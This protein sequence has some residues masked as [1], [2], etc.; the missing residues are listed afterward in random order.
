[1]PRKVIIN[2]EQ[3]VKDYISHIMSTKDLCKSYKCSETYLYRILS[4]YNIKRNN[5]RKNN[6][7]WK[8]YEEIS[9]IYWNR[10]IVSAKKRNLAFDINIKEMW[11]LFLKQERKCSISG[12]EIGFAKTWATQIETTASIDR[13]NSQI[14]YI[15]TN[16]QWVHK[17]VNM[18]KQNMNE[19]E[20]IDWCNK[21]L[22]NQNKKLEQ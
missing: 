13:I 3:I 14:G 20:F 10:I 4:K 16:V 21:I 17:R 2:E 8:G 18:M 22:I 9:G 5:I 19:K 6:S 11:N 7:S 15:N 12:V 1:M